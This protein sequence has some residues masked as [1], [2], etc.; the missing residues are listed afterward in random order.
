M[1]FTNVS[2]MDLD[3]PALRRIVEAGETVEVEDEQV[4]AGMV[5]QDEV[6]EPLD[7]EQGDGA[8]PDTNEAAAAAESTEG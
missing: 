3:V 8:T 6:W 2:G 5:G 4:A 1:R 7:V